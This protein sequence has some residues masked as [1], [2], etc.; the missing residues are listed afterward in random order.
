[1]TRAM[2]HLYL[3]HAR[4]RLIWGDIRENSPS[5]FLAEIP[6]ELIERPTKE[7]GSKTKDEG[8]GTDSSLVV[9]PSSQEV[10]YEIA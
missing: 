5:R 2:K 9:R 10:H 4:S 8:P 1:M 3:T 6:R 7:A